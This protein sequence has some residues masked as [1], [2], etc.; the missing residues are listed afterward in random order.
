MVIAFYSKFIELH[1]K[2]I[3]IRNIITG[4]TLPKKL[5]FGLFYRNQG[6]KIM[7]AKTMFGIELKDRIAKRLDFEKIGAWAYS[8]YLNHSNEINDSGFDNILLTL[9]TMEL[10]PQFYFT[11]EELNAIANDLIA[12]K[13][14]NL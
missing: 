1:P 5:E 6:G 14:V 7:Y 13:E 2:T 9:T 12:G 10:G 11:Y 3:H 4:R 8:I